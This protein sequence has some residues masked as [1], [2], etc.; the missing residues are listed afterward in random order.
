[1]LMVKLVDASGEMKIFYKGFVLLRQ[2]AI[3]IYCRIVELV[4]VHCSKF[5]FLVNPVA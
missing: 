1:M 2:A 5:L 4:A 3:L